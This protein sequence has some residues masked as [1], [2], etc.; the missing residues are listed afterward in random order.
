MIATKRNNFRSL[1][2]LGLV[3]VVAI[4]GFVFLRGDSGTS[5]FTLGGRV[6]PIAAEDIMVMHLTKENKEYRFERFGPNGWSLNGAVSDYLDASAMTD[7]VGFL[8]SIEGGR[9]LPGT[10]AEDRRYAF[11][12]SESIRLVV[13]AT[14]GREVRLAL[15]V[16][17]PVT[18]GVYASGAGRPGCFPVGQGLRNR[19]RALPISVQ[20]KNL[21]P[22]F[23]QTTLTEVNVW[24]GS[25][26]L[27]LKPADSR[28]WIK[29]PA[30]GLAQLG[31]AFRNYHEVYGDRRVLRDGQAWLLAEPRVVEKLLYEASQVLV[32]DIITTEDSPGRMEEWSLLPPW[33]EI[34]FHGP[35]INQDP[36]A[37]PPDELS[38]SFGP[39][40]E[41]DYIPF[42]RQGNLMLSDKMA[43]LTLGE[44]LGKWVDTGALPFRVE[45]GD[46]LHIAGDGNV[47]LSAYPGDDND[48][49]RWVGRIS[50]QGKAALDER[51]NQNAIESLITNLDRMNFFQVLPPT[52]NAEVLAETERVHLT[53]WSS[54]E[55]LVGPRKIEFGWL[56]LDHLS[57]DH[58]TRAT[59]L[60]AEEDGQ[61]PAGM[62]I[63]GTG[64]LLQ[65]P[66][67][68]V[69]RFR[70]LGKD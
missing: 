56:D 53:F 49:S 23:D 46:S 29:E 2:P 58:A 15:G 54:K 20:E 38:L 40:L 42:I 35:A 12:S 7:L 27:S 64:K 22:P 36:L 32:R 43:A 33:R 6:F 21:L 16:Q 28:W 1:W 11:D 4:L 63:P 8:S 51:G 5:D 39:P 30:D 9:V 41:N 13:F 59:K 3:L 14:E 48:I 31:V 10:A 60:A 19:L 34:V 70:N 57:A 26:M 62:W 50:S 37:G 45:M 55:G 24:R 47:A 66:A 65:V 25:E 69:I 61:R 44:P 68:L 18:G 67:H 17:N 52:D